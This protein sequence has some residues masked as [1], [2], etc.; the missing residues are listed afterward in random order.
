[1]SK[2][3]K[4]PRLL[5]TNDDG[6]NAPG[7]ETLVKIANQL[8]DDVWIVAPE[9]NQSGAGHSL[10]LSTPIRYREISD[11]KFALE[12]TPTDCVLFGVRQLMRDKAPDMVLSGVNRGANLADDV[13]YSGTIAG[14]MEGCLLGIRSVA[15]SQ[16]Y[17][18][19][20][21]LKWST[22]EHFGAPVIA[23]LMTVEWDKDV[24]MNVNFPDT[25][26]TSVK[27]IEV[28][29]QGH[30]DLSVEVLERIDPRGGAYY[31]L[32]YGRQAHH[33]DRGTD[34]AAVRAGFVSVSPLDLDLTHEGMRRKMAGL[35]A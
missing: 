9:R 6:I 34:I 15:L 1:M 18:D 25:L 35:F 5:L 4:S 16:A 17:T 26:A 32:S 22:A 12:G 21:P 31:W 23:K 13:T 2:A 24:F 30:L 7:L 19:P 27:G 3:A 8:S 14:A 28:T 10:S 20:H 29:H 11:R 33:P